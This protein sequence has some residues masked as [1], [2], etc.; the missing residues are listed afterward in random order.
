MLQ[1]G[2]DP[3]DTKMVHHRTMEEDSRIRSLQTPMDKNVDTYSED[4]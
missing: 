4:I 1:R 3:L 2:I